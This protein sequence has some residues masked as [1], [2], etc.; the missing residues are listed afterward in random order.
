MHILIDAYNVIKKICGKKLASKADI[1]W[2][3][4]SLVRYAYVKNHALT[5]IFDGGTVPWAIS[6]DY[7]PLCT[8]RWVGDGTKAD[9]CIK[10]FLYK[11]SKFHLL[12]SCDRELVIHAQDNKTP[13]IE[14]VFFWHFVEKTF[15]TQKSIVNQEPQN[16]K[17]T[18]SHTHQSIDEVMHEFSYQIIN[19]DMHENDNNDIFFTKKHLSK[20]QIQLYTIIKKL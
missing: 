19:K 14:S 6:K 5:I 17:K 15:E 4:R 11:N 2:F 16:V 1:E 13:S 18:Y 12:V 7:S 20:E 9:D 10:E 3:I 8:V